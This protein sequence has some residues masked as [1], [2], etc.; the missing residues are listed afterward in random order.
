M[1]NKDILQ[2]ESKVWA[3]AD[4]LIPIKT[5]QFIKVQLIGSISIFVHAKIAPTQIIILI[6]YFLQ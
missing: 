1:I 2:Y 5:L 3:T 6:N 4:L